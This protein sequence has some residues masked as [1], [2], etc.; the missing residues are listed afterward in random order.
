MLIY[1]DYFPN[2]S[3]FFR[4]G[5]G[6]S[7]VCGKNFCIPLFGGT[8]NRSYSTDFISRKILNIGSLF[9]GLLFGQSLIIDKSICQNSISSKKIITFHLSTVFNALFF[10]P[11]PKLVS[12]LAAVYNLEVSVQCYWP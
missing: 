3:G 10:S 7:G 8:Q 2:S 11:M 5:G 9:K 4:Q 12:S 1:N 6:V